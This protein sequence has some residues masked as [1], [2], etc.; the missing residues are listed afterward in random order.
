M[1]KFIISLLVLAIIAIGV[2]WFLVKPK[3]TSEKKEPVPLAINSKSDAFQA[4]FASMMTTYYTLKDAFVNWDT[5]AANKAA[6]ELQTKA[7]GLPVDEIKADTNI[8]QTARDLSGS[9]VAET[10]GLVGE[11]N[12]EQKRRAFYILSEAYV[13]PRA[14]GAL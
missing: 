10:K 3:D 13:Q 12:I 4:S 2:Y 11:T 14:H 6:L 5:V 1:K 7:D 9:I 8:I